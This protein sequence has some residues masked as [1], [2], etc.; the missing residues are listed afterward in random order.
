MIYRHRSAYARNCRKVGAALLFIASTSALADMEVGSSFWLHAERPDCQ[1][2]ARKVTKRPTV[3]AIGEPA[4][5]TE[6]RLTVSSVFKLDGVSY[7]ALEVDE[8]GPL[9]MAVMHGRAIRP[10]SDVEIGWGAV[11]CISMISSAEWSSRRGAIR[12]KAEQAAAASAAEQDRRAKLPG[13]RLGMTT[14]QVRDGTSWGPPARVNTLTTAKGVR[15]VW[16]YGS[17]QAL[18]F[19]NDKLIAIEQ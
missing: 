14:R 19:F 15:E 2:E 7:Y 4:L 9:Y 5:T 3:F 18:Y 16:H 10:S 12:Q 13:A 17:S 8:V 6:S 1:S 11:P